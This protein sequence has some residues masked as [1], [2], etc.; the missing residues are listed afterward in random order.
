METDA[1]VTATA[2]PNQQV[3]R[4]L[5]HVLGEYAESGCARY[6]MPGHKGRGMGAFLPCQAARWDVT[7]L[8]MTDNL[9]EPT[10]CI[11]QTQQMVADAYGARASFLLVNGS[12]AALQ[13]MLLSLDP[14][15]RLLLYRD[16]HRSALAGA[17]LSG[18]DTVL[19]TPGYDEATGLLALPTADELSAALERTGATAV[20]VTSPNA[21]GYCADLAALSA[22]AHAHGALLLVD[23]AHGAHFAFSDRL[24]AS[25]A[26]AADLWGHSQHK[27]LCALTQAATLHLG[28]CRIEPERVQRALSLLQTTSPSYLLMSSIN[29]SVFMAARTDWAK[30]IDRCEALRR[31][32]DGIAG[33]RSG[34]ALPPGAVDYDKTRIVIDVSDRNISGFEADTALQHSG[35]FVEM[36]DDRRLVLI[37]SPA[38]DPVW[39]EKLLS[40]LASLP[41]GRTP[42]RI[43]PAWHTA[44]SARRMTIREA[45]LRRT[46]RVP[47]AHAAGRTAGEAIGLYPPGIALIAPGEEIRRE[48]VEELLLLR[49]VGAVLFGVHGGTIAAVSEEPL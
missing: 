1:P 8:A 26:G 4:S 12:T 18:V 27:T 14:S 7:E 22:A 19:E 9:H 13:A 23:A 42:R 28:A 32:I 36:A 43:L 25:P 17:A 21:Y 34:P 47:L 5:P 44:P 10:G 15:D 6:H 16:C 24:P 48:Q 45:S 39:D 30:H 41:Y 38:D 40:A 46:E 37:T 31:Q 49:R 29:W 35:V 33:L 20:L 2:Q 11:R 3:Q